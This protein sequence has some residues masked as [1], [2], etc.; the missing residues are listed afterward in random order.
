MSP[1]RPSSLLRRLLLPLMVGMLASGVAACPAGRAMTVVVP[2]AAGG[3]TDAIARL[4]AA[5]LGRELGRRVGVRN[6]PGASGLIAVREVLGAVPDGCTLQSGSS[7]TVLLVPLRNLHAGFA[8]SDLRPLAEVGTTEMML[9]GSRRL[10]ARDLAE[11]RAMA[12]ATRPLAAGHPGQDSV[13]AVM[14]GLLSRSQGLALNE[15]PYSGSAPLIN[16][17]VA[18]HLD[19]GVVAAPSALPLIRRQEVRLLTVVDRLPG[20][21][22][23]AGWGG[24]FAPAAAEP[25]TTAAARDALRR[26]LAEPRVQQALAAQGVI[27]AAPHEQDGFAQQVERDAQRLSEQHRAVRR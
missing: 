19:L 22:H 15:I 14:L 16:D 5:E 21:E 2:Y 11:L 3:S 13:Q 7:N 17:L 12:T 1:R 20:F 18:G 6:V 8:P 10:A 25:Q 27:A 9:I 24:W 26:V 4:L 23:L